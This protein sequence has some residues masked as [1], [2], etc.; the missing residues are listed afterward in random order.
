MAT[1]AY[2][3]IIVRGEQPPL[4]SIPEVASLTCKRGTPVLINANGFVDVCGAA[5]AS[6]YGLAAEDGHN[7]TEGQYELLVEPITNTRE[8]E[9]TLLETLAQTQLSEAVGLVKDATTGFWYASTADAG[10]QA[11]IV[12]YVRGPGGWAI[13]DVKARVFIRFDNANIQ[14]GV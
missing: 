7:G 11:K 1:G 12:D 4:V 2:Q 10:A 8:Y 3:A 13:G 14:V 5:P 6:I 9:I